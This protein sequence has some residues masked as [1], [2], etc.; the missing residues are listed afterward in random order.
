MFPRESRVKRI[1]PVTNT[2]LFL[3]KF[4]YTLLRS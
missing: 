4:R 3:G 1:R 2:K